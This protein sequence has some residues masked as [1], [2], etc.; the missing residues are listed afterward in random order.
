MRQVHLRSNFLFPYFKSTVNK[1]DGNVDQEQSMK[2]F[3]YFL[4]SPHL[5]S[6]QICTFSLFILFVIC[7]HSCSKKPD[8]NIVARVGDINIT[9]EEFELTYQFNPYLSR[10]PE[11]RQ[12][13]TIHLQT[14]IAEKLIAQEGYRDGYGDRP[15]IKALSEQYTREALIENLWQDEIRSKITISESEIYDA[16]LK[17]KRTRLFKYLIFPDGQMAERAYLHLKNGV[18]FSDVAQMNGI[19]PDFIPEDSVSFG[20][21]LDF[22]ESFVFQLGSN[23]IGKPIKIGQYYFVVKQMEDKVDIFTSADDYKRQYKRIDKILRKRKQKTYYQDYIK[24]NFTKPPYNLDRQ[25]FKILVKKLEE[26]LIV[27]T[28]EQRSTIQGSTNYILENSFEHLGAFLESPIVFFEGEN[29][30]TIKTLL[31]RLQISPYPIVLSSPGKFRSSMIAATKMILDDEILVTL[32]QKADL[33]QSTFVQSQSHMWTDYLVF[34]KALKDFGS[35]S[36]SNE[37]KKG[38]LQISNRLD[39]YLLDLINKYDISINK[40]L[41][42]T[43]APIKSDM[44]VMKTHFPQRVIAP[45]LIPLNNTPKFQQHISS[46]LIQN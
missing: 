23:E 4:L 13:K 38:E 44:V 29:Q 39:N 5:F 30:W 22:L 46:K 9:L 28:S 2:K 1:I 36:V 25:T 24:S 31:K 27:N 15:Q 18:S 40:V 10:I 21:N 33:E 8:P 17:S 45:V 37:E 41:F 43:L 16:Y 26:V 14:L 34:Q 12:A 32:A 6:K 11:S 42:D 19:N 35:L 20:S 7:T 3:G